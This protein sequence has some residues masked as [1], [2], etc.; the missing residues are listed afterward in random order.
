MS[1]NHLLMQVSE[2]HSMQ[3]YAEW[4]QQCRVKE[5]RIQDMVNK[6]F[7]DSHEYI[8]SLSEDEDQ[9]V[10][11]ASCRFLRI[12]LRTRIPDNVFAC[13]PFPPF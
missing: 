5:L 10:S 12:R 11:L 13:S 2:A 3:V 9:V 6:K 4:I 7:S 1:T 8:R